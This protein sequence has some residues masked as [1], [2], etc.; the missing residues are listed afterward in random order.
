MIHLKYGVFPFWGKP[1]GS[2]VT[3]PPWLAAEER[4]IGDM[5]Q[6]ASSA[7]AGGSVGA[8]TLLC[9]EGPDV[10]Q[11]LLTLEKLLKPREVVGLYDF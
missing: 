8:D 11:R 4:C 5:R 10:F 7:S 1:G 9:P 3:L 6:L 2:T